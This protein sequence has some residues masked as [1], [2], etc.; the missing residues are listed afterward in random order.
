MKFGQ[1]VNSGHVDL[2]VIKVTLTLKKKKKKDSFF[3]R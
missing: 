2:E 1:E 3:E